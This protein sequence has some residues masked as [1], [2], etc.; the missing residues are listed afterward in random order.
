MQMYTDPNRVRADVP[1]RVEGNPVF[2]YHDAF[3]A[4]R[5]EVDDLKTR[6]REGRVGDVEVKK[7]LIAALERFLAPVRERRVALEHDGDIVADILADGNREVRVV[8]RETMALVR[9]AMGITYYR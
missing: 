8:A 9:D 3:N 5:A 1:G 7:K 6:Y 2:I 4:D